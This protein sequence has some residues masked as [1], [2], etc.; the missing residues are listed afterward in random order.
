MVGAVAGD[1]EAQ[2][3]GRAAGPRPSP[4]RRSGPFR[5]PLMG[6][7]DHGKGEALEAFGEASLRRIPVDAASVRVE[8]RQQRSQRTS[9]TCCMSSTRAVV[10]TTRSASGRRRRTGRGRRRRGTRVGPTS[11]GTRTPAASRRGRQGRRRCRCASGGQGPSPPG[12]CAAVPPAVLQQRLPEARDGLGLQVEPGEPEG[13]A[14]LVGVPPRRR[15]RWVEQPRTEVG[16]ER[17]SG[18]LL[19]NRR[20]RHRRRVVVRVPRPT[21]SS[22]GMRR[23]AP[24]GSL[25]SSLPGAVEGVLAMTRRHRQEVVDGQGCAT[26]GSTCPEHVAAGGRRRGHRAGTGLRRGRTRR[27]ST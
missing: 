4:R 2:V 1:R 3:P 20:E 6:R 22:G 12:G 21:G 16:Q 5:R 10:A 11:T 8:G 14:V 23:N 7:D 18:V 15:C 26:A 13:H 24:T 17:L 9:R 19:D 27:R 25:G